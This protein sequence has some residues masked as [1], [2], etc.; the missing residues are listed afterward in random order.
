[1]P[2]LPLSDIVLFPSMIA[3]LVVNTDFD[4]ALKLRETPAGWYLDL[5]VDTAWSAG[6]GRQLVTTAM[7]GKTQIAGCAYENPDGSP[8]RI[9]TDYCGNPRNAANP[10]V[11]PL[12]T[13][14][15]GTR[16][17]KVW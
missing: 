7:L 11:G 8:L 4:P 1:M 9:D 13:L 17:I 16:S 10:A 15:P 12:E 6:P 5:N 3:P 2:V 14:A